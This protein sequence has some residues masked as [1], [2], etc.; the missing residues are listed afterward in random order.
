M[1]DWIKR[2]NLLW[3][4]VLLMG[5]HGLLYYS[6]GTNNWLFVAFSASVVDTALAGVL[7]L[8]LPDRERGN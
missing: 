8:L 1:V 3:L 6:L 2:I 7:K 5:F 4:F